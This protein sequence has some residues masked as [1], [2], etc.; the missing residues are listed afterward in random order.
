MSEESGLPSGWATTKLK[1]VL[2]IQY[3]KGLVEAARDTTGNIPVYGSSGVV[4]FHSHALTTQPT[5]IV[6]RKGSVGSVHYSPGPCWPIDTV[7]FTE[8]HADLDLKFFL[9]LLTSLDLSRLDK[10]TTIPGLSRDDYNVVQVA[11]APVAE[12]RRIVAAIEQ[13]F[14][15]LDAGVAAL[16][17]VQA[18]LKRYRASVL[19]AAVEGQLTEQWRAEHPNTEPASQ[20]LGRILAERRARWEADLRNKGKDPAKAHYQE[21]ELLDM[22]ILPALPMGWM[23]ATVEMLAS[24]QRNSLSSG[25]FGSAL[26]TKDYQPYG[27]PVIRS[28]NVGA[29]EFSAG[30]FVFV[31]HEKASQLARSLAYPGDLVI[32][33]VG[34]SCGNVAV[35]PG[36]VGQAVLSQN[37]NK[38]TLDESVISPQFAAMTMQ[39][40]LIRLQFRDKTTDTARQ[41]LSLTN[42]KQVHL[43]LPPLSEQ[44]TLVAEVEQRLSVVSELEITIETQLKRAER[45]RQS[46]LERAFSGQLVSQDPDDKPAALLLERIQVERAAVANGRERDARKGD[47]FTET[48]AQHEIPAATAPLQPSAVQQGRLWEADGH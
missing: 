15:R 6:G 24:P 28:Q 43:P 9:Y 18:A 17:R 37:C 30:N 46:I 3:G 35:V 47:R 4:G 26:G 42:I 7:Y 32:V 33:A 41:F 12:Q 19:K 14:T 31:S 39:T 11:L 8:G 21:P 16:K 22:T 25:P 5:L 10:S 29:G 2:P 36:K 45:L 23:W 38:A 34:V 1:D 27:V 44:E 48:S 20:L 40:E 13:Q